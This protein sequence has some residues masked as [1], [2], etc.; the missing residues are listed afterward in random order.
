MYRSLGFRAVY[1]Q[2]KFINYFIVVNFDLSKTKTNQGIKGTS[3][4][5]LK[6]IS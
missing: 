3:S 6:S 1:S 4:E 2:I 5:I